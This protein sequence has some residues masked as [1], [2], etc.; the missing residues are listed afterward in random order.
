[1]LPDSKDKI[2]KKASRQDVYEKMEKKKGASNNFLK[3]LEL[4][5]KARNR[6]GNKGGAA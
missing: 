1:M 2:I 4:D 5:K 3:M 6:S